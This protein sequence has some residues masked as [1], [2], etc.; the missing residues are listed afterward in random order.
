[1][2]KYFVALSIIVSTVAAGPVLADVAPDPTSTE[3]DDSDDTSATE[4]DTANNLD[5]DGNGGC[6]LRFIT[7]A[8]ANVAP[9]PNLC[10]DKNIGESCDDYLGKPGTCEFTCMPKK[11][12]KSGKLEFTSCSRCV[13][14]KPCADPNV[15]GTTSSPPILKKQ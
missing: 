13:L 12:E 2:K 4:T 8:H 15:C 14:E 7:D 1:M 3:T 5:T 11:N 9:P 6:S 10:Y